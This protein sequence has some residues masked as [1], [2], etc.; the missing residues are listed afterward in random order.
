MAKI[1]IHRALT[2][3]KKHHQSLQEVANNGIFLGT[4]SNSKK[5]P[6]LNGFRTVDEL[7]NRITSDTDKVNTLLV[8]IPKI[9]EAISKANLETII[10]FNGRN[11]SITELL[12]IKDTV[13]SRKDYLRS[14]RSQ[15]NR[16][17]LQVELID[18]EISSKLVGLTDPEA[19]KQV[20]DT[21]QSV[22]GVSL[23]T[24]NDISPEMFIKQLEDELN[25]LEY[26]LDVTLS[27]TNLST[28]IE[29][30]LGE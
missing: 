8:T 9:K 26:E 18:K 21:L 20:R 22:D 25:F 17:N 24:A 27:E 3:L 1:S 13:S 5:T 2:L 11:V 23:I 14:L 6:T 30:D 15:M 29:I 19:I 10:S 28:F 16:V 7:K 4:I 12:A